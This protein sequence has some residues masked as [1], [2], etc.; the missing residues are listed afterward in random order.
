LD[1]F[2]K[3]CVLEDEITNAREDLKDT[4]NE[5][6]KR[7]EEDRR[8]QEEEDRKRAEEE[9]RRKKEENYYWEALKTGATFAA[10][11]LGGYMFSDQNLK[12]NITT[13]PYSEYNDIGLRG[14]CWEWNEDAKK[15]FG[16]TGEGCGV[17]AQEVRMLYPRAVLQGKDGYS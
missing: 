11:F 2:E 6:R 13:L 17:I 15:S 10:T 14:V 1:A 16:L 7:E 5:K 8:R 12:Y 9:E 4:L 3:D